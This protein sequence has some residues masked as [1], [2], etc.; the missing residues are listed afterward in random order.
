ML[1]HQ[2]ESHRKAKN[3]QPAHRLRIVVFP[4][5]CFGADLPH[6]VAVPRVRHSESVV[7]FDVCKVLK[8]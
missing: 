6:T 5:V 1:R 8:S 2:I 7:I 3:Q 4:V